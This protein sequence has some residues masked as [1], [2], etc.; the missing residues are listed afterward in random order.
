MAGRIS[1]DLECEESKGKLLSVKMDCEF[2]AHYW[3]HGSHTV[4]KMGRLSW[5]CCAFAHSLAEGSQSWGRMGSAGPA[6]L[7]LP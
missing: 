4:G 2:L 3:F 6:A 7:L 1:R 5:S